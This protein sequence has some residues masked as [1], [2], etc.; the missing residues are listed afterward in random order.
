METNWEQGLPNTQWRTWGSKFFQFHAVFWKFLA[1]SY[2][3]AQVPPTPTKSWCPHLGEILN[4]PVI[5][6]LFTRAKSVI[7]CPTHLTPYQRLTLIYMLIFAKFRHIFI[8][9]YI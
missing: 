2:V 9:G 1:K 7:L 3:G 5:P 8:L 4:P 6:T